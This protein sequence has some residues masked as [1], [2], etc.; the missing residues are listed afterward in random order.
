MSGINLWKSLL[1]ITAANLSLIGASTAYAQDEAA[2][3]LWDGAF[4]KKRA[5]AKKPAAESPNRKSTAYKRVPPK[6]TETQNPQSS[7]PQNSATPTKSDGKPDGEVLGVT[8]WRLRPARD[9][10]KREDRLLLEDESS[11]KTEWM[12]ERVEAGTVFAPT[13]KV[14]LS[15]ESPRDGYLYI[16]DREQYA[17]G[18]V[19]DPYLIFPTLRNRSGSNSVGA[20]KLIELPERSAFDL[21]PMRPDYAGEGLTIL[22]TSE[23]LEDVQP[24]P[25]HKKLEAEMVAR[26]ESQWASAVDIYELVDGAGKP[27]TKAEK[28]AGQDGARILTQDDAM[29]QTLYHVRGKSG[30]P[31]LVTVALRIKK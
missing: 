26:W 16:I 5:E 17:D 15:I 7:K 27:Y 13:D 8:V 25:R 12:A 29:P 11:K 19:S 22:V 31:L 20:G 14:R 2:R 10:D 6:K 23:P 1:L 4:L 28:E 18:T 9:D 21:K 3:Q 30:S 24:G